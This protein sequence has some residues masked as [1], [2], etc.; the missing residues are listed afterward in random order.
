[1]SLHL[2][3]W[4]SSRSRTG[5][6][7]RRIHVAFEHVRKLEHIAHRARA[8]RTTFRTLF[9]CR[10]SRRFWIRE[11]SCVSAHTV[12]S[13]DAQARTAASMGGLI[14]M[15]RVTLDEH[16]AIRCGLRTALSGVHKLLSSLARLSATS[17][18][19]ANSARHA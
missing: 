10:P 4:T 14:S 6:F 16:I 17:R 1:M 8:S 19:L 11:Q 5:R 7:V 12:G 2:R 3:R 15:F 18:T 13:P 9:A